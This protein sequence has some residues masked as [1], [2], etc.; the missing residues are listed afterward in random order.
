MEIEHSLHLDFF[1]G[2]RRKL[3]LWNILKKTMCFPLGIWGVFSSAELILGA[4]DCRA[5][6]RTA[7]YGIRRAQL[8]LLINLAS[9]ASKHTLRL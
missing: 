9:S 8:H 2:K 4:L 5:A 1:F 7:V 3:K 6:S